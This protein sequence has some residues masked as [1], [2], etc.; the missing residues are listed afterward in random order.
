[1]SKRFRTLTVVLLACI[2]FCV[3]FMFAQRAMAAETYNLVVNFLFPDSTI[4]YDPFTAII[5]AG[6]NYQTNLTFPTIQGYQ[7]YIED[8]AS[9]SLTMNINL[10]NV[11]ENHIITV[12][13][14]P[15]QVS[16]RVD[17]YWQN[18][19]NDDYTL[20]ESETLT[21]YTKQRPEGLENEYPGFYA[22][23]YEAPEL[24][25]DGSTVI[26]VYYDR[27]Y[28]LM[29]FV[30][31]GGVGADPIYERYGTSVTAPTPTREGYTFNGWSPS[32]P[33]TIPVDGG[34]Y[35]ASW[36]PTTNGTTYTVL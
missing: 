26:R 11:N 1:M 21:G 32:V 28:Y 33:S 23:M 20:H 35:T 22:L 7:P 9:P 3:G 15:A 30:T 34:T 12:W 24:A 2:L 36:T 25:A 5:D 14:K 10:T 4:A 27:Y 29:N 18:V 6:A 13:Y 31:N 8:D 16:Y 17:H 19:N